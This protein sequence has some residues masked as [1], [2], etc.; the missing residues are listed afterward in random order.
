MGVGDGEND[1]VV[2][3][4]RVGV[5]VGVGVVGNGIEEGSGERSIENNIIFCFKESI[6]VVI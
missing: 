5:E 3:G 1:V 2:V 4:A 6:Y